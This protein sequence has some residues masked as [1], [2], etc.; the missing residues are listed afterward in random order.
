MQGYLRKKSHEQ[1]FA[2]GEFCEVIS[3][4]THDLTKARN[5]LVHLMH[6]VSKYATVTI[7]L[8]QDALGAVRRIP[9]VRAPRL[10]LISH[11]CQ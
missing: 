10:N 11:V 6:Q 5:Q 3:E 2:G 1:G 4:L 9:I 8:P 7:L